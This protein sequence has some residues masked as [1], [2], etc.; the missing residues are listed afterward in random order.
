MESLRN[1]SGGPWGGKMVDDRFMEFMINLFGPNVMNKFKRDEVTEYLEFIKDIELK[2]INGCKEDQHVL[3][4]IPSLLVEIFEQI[5]GF[6]FSNCK[7]LADFDVSLLR[8]NKI[9]IK[10]QTFLSFF[11]NVTNQIV[12]YAKQLVCDYRCDAIIMAGGFSECKYLQ[13]RIKNS[14]KP[15]PVWIPEQCMLSVL[16][17]AVIYGHMPDRI[18]A[19]YCA[20]TYGISINRPYIPDMHVGGSTIR[21]GQQLLCEDCF[22]KFFTKGEIVKVG[23]KRQKD[24]HSTHKGVRESVRERPKQITVYVS[25][26]ED[27]ELVKDATIHGVISIPPP[28]GG[29]PEVTDGK[30]EMEVGDVEMIVR[31]I[32]NDKH[33]IDA[34]V[35]FYNTHL[36]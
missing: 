16:K 11:E 32:D 13:E 22:E 21:H 2:K 6:K 14:F 26:Q 36:H 17:G 35:D 28:K 20:Y 3:I 12:D 8:G 31:F 23:A 24:V 15:T 30:V 27:P 7:R 34:T 5:N 1:V 25:D 4:Y 29:W 10:P 19:R 18:N 33:A 9:R